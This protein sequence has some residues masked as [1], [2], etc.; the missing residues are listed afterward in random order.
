MSKITSK[1][2]LNFGLIAASNFLLLAVFVL[3]LITFASGKEIYVD[4]SASGSED[5]SAAHPY[6][7][8]SSALDKAK[9]GDKIFVAKGKYKENIVVDDGI[10]IHGADRDDVIIEA[11][12]KK[13]PVVTMDDDTEINKVTIRKGR[14]GIEV[15]K[16]DEDVSIVNCII[17]ENSRDGIRLEKGSTKKKDAVS[18]TDSIIRD[19]GWTGVYSQKRRVVLMDNEIE[20]N[21]KDGVELESGSS[22]WVEH[23][24]I[25]DNHGVGMKLFLDGSD[26]WTKSNTIRD[27][28]K[29]GIEAK[30]F[31]GS[32]RID[33][34]RTKIYGNNGFAISRVQLVNMPG[35]V[36][37][38]VT[39]GDP[40]NEFYGNV[41]GNVSH[42]FMV[43]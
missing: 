3:P 17:E 7:T 19:N 21:E 12:D 2:S 42:I 28:K 22:A 16:D 32:G 23:N 24:K 31:G 41:A 37:G 14:I 1:K 33:I 34:S 18:I 11:D 25:K 10:E 6:K 40:K 39:Y 13:R 5:G 15:R 4:D 26:I 35:S 27:N 29:N 9:D 8:I 43:Y 20:N 38:G 30:S 36:W